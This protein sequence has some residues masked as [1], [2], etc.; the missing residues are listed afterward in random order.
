MSTI[1][2]QLFCEFSEP[3]VTV[4]TA[5]ITICN[6]LQRLCTFTV[7]RDSHMPGLITPMSLQVEQAGYTMKPFH[8]FL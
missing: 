5:V 3:L 7:S 6:T 8:R 4:S 2:N 1:I